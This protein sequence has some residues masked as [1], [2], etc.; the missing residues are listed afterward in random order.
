MEAGEGYPGRPSFL[1]FRR[2]PLPY[3]DTGGSGAPV[4]MIHG[5]GGDMSDFEHALPELARRG[6]RVLALDLPGFGLDA[7]AEVTPSIPL[8]LEA[9]DTLIRE[10][11]LGPVHLVGASMGGQVSLRYALG[12]PS[13]VKSLV[14]AD[15]GGTFEA[16][17]GQRE[18]A[19]RINRQAIILG[20]TDAQMA[21]SVRRM[22]HADE[23]PFQRTRDRKIRVLRSDQAPAVALSIERSVES[24]YE[25]LLTPDELARLTL[26]VLV[27]WGEQ[28]R[29]I[30]VE[31][32]KRLT[33]HLPRASI[34]VI[35]ACGHMPWIEKVGEFVDRIASF[36]AGAGILGDGGPDEHPDRGR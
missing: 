31:E 2:R 21:D 6:F 24:I 14:I 5:L 36:L 30:G 19:L 20:R 3:I 8:F 34:E 13:R 18:L 16:M 12:E 27:L 4:I 23:E 11:S 22:F 9:V 26:P 28:D 10:L 1:T 29:I 35:P 25:L 17:E 32:G 15:T 7:S 33:S